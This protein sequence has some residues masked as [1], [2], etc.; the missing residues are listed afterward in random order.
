MMGGHGKK[1]QAAAK[2][3]SSSDRLRKSAAPDAMS[4]ELVSA[5]A[6]D[7]DMTDSERARVDARIRER[8]GVFFSDLFYAISHHYFAPEVAETLWGQVL[9]SEADPILWTKMGFI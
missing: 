3:E 9:S 7:R 1:T 2:D 4:V 6:G 8:G 5:F